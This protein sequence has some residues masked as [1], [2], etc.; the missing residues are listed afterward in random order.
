ME[1]AYD[2]ISPKA[3]IKIMQHIGLP[4]K[5]MDLI[6]SIT[7]NDIAKV[8]IN[9]KLSPDFQINSG[10]KQGDPLSPLL[11]NLVM[12]LFAN[13]IRNNPNIQGLQISKRRPNAKKKINLFADD[14]IIFG[15]GKS[16]YDAIEKTIHLF[17]SATAS[18]VNVSKSKVIKIKSLWIST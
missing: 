18:K 5:L 10:V 16:D 11:F 17:E 4:N 3:L 14:C 9:N 1:K 8:Y 2:R 7:S 12:E 6:S 13:A 15:Y